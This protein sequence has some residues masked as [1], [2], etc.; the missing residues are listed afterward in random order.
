MQKLFVCYHLPTFLYKY[1]SKSYFK[2]LNFS[3]SKM[4]Y[5][6][7]NNNI[8]EREYFKKILGLKIESPKTYNTF[9]ELLEYTHK[10]DFKLDGTYNEEK[11]IKLTSNEN[12][13]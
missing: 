10:L 1:M 9:E 4:N 5:E 8:S 3:V 13:I 12:E 6:I 11:E 2:K 7:L